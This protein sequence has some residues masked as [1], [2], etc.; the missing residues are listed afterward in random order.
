MSSPYDTFDYP[1]YWKFR[2]YEHRS[3]VFTIKTI[4]K[5][6]PR[7]N[8]LLE[9]GS[10]YGRLTYLYVNHCKKIILSD[11]SRKLL[12]LAKNNHKSNKIKYLISD[13]ESLHKYIKPSS[14]DLI[15]MIRVIH[16]IKSLEKAF[17]QINKILKDNGYLILEFPNK[18]HMK[19]VIKNLLICNFKY[20]IDFLPVDIKKSKE[21]QTLPFINYHPLM[22]KN[23]L[24]KYG[25]SIIEKYSTSNIR[26]KYFKN[27]F[28]IKTLLILEKLLQKPFSIL[29]FGPS[30]FVLARK[31]NKN[32]SL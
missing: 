30:I 31:D 12:K 5:K 28:S 16:H 2:K 15:V 24:E 8:N 27:I 20:F 4:F 19:N 29:N 3:E 6:L 17:M 10:G 14:I 21:R 7:V 11:P 9:I 1:S 23:V 18:A 13:L 25:F 22:I 32:S 26:H